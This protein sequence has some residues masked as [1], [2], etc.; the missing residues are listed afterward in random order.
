VELLSGSPAFAKSDV[1]AVKAWFRAYLTW[2]TTHPYGTKERDADN[3]HG[4]CWSMQAAAF[5]HLVN[6]QEQLS[7]IRNYFK[8][9]FLTKQM[10]TDG[11]F[12]QELRRT[13]PYGYSLFVIDA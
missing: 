10:A 9:T 5:A 6:D 1:E 4:V 7:W 13:K 11:S 8:T 3:N 12:P 2:I